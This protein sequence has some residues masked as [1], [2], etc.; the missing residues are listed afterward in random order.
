MIQTI[1]IKIRMLIGGVIFVS[2]DQK[3]WHIIRYKM[4]V[5]LNTNLEIAYLIVK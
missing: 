4:K 2:L 1:V 3:V 5:V